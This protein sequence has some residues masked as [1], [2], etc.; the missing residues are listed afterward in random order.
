MPPSQTLNRNDHDPV[1]QLLKQT[2]LLSSAPECVLRELSAIA[3]VIGVEAGEVL[4]EPGDCGSA[5]YIGVDG[6]VRAHDGDLVLNRLGPGAAFGEMS[7]LDSENRSASITA[8]TDTSLIVLDQEPVREVLGREPEAMGFIIGVLCAKLRDVVTDHTD[9]SHH[10][11][12]L[13]REL[14]IGRQIQAGFLPEHLPEVDGW[15][16]SAYFLAAREVAGDFYDAFVVGGRSR[17]GLVIGDVCGKGVG[18]ALFMTLF[19]SLLRASALAGEFTRWS[20][21]SMAFSGLDEIPDDRVAIRNTLMLT[22]NYITATHGKANMFATVFYALLDPVTGKLTYANC[23]HEAP[24]IF[25]ADGVRARLQP[26]GPVLGVFPG[27]DI[28]VGEAQLQPGETLLTFTDG[29]PDAQ[30][31]DG[32][33]FGEQRLIDLLGHCHCGADQCLATVTDALCT[34]V[35]CNDP[36]DDVTLLAARRAPRPHHSEAC[37]R[38]VTESIA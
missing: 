10:L 18:A 19:R 38:G 20:D 33:R 9:R 7:M 32:E 17:I 23:G 34:F 27:L 29:I 13:E 14:E 26:T 25:S 31:S 37:D 3:R 30:R 35:D 28:E 15:Q 11:Q 4:F 21:A 24:A 1:E 5:M 36:F 22:N 12:T 16:L 2:P 8:E 6:R